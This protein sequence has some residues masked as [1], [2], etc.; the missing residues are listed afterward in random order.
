MEWC[1]NIELSVPT[2]NLA[3]ALQS[4]VEA[5]LERGYS[6]H[7]TYNDL[8][9]LALELRREGKEERESEVLEVMDVLTGWCAP[10]ARI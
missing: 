10:S 6:R 3:D 5:R 2:H 8:S 9:Q 4:A 7:F 1:R